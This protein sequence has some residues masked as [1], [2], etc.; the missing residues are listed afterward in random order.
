MRAAR[1]SPEERPYGMLADGESR[2]SAQLI[3]VT[4][5]ENRRERH[6]CS[7]LCN[8]RLKRQLKRTGLG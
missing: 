4:A 5:A 2:V 8:A 3:Q 6:V 1:F 7:G